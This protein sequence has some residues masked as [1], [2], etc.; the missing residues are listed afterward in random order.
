MNRSPHY[1]VIL[2]SKEDDIADLEKW[3][4]RLQ[5]RI[6]EEIE[7]LQSLQSALSS[8]V[9]GEVPGA[10]VL[11]AHHT[12]DASSP[13]YEDLL[14]DI[15]DQRTRQ[16]QTVAKMRWRIGEIRG[17]VEGGTRVVFIVENLWGV[18]GTQYLMAEQDISHLFITQQQLTLTFGFFPIFL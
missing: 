4:D 12:T 3:L 2:L 9:P 13:D 6:S 18:F 14:G 11:T 10:I 1:D 7:G 15:I 17:H 16:H 5:E 8:Q